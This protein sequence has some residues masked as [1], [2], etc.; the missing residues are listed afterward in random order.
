MKMEERKQSERMQIGWIVFGLLTAL[1]AFEIW[2]SLS[3]TPSLP[4]L[5]PT[6]VAKAALIVIYFMHISEM[7]H[8]GG[9]E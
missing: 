6:S 1:T 9:N 7:W 8:R 3:V 4:Y 2:V 5:V